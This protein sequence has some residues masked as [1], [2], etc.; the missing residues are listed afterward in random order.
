MDLIH[1][2]DDQTEPDGMTALSL[3][4]PR[5]V[6]PL[7][8]LAASVALVAAM[9]VTAQLRPTAPPA[10]PAQAPAVEGPVAPPQA[11]I[12]N[13][14]GSL[15]QIDHSIAAWTANLEANDRDF[16][17]ARNLGLLYEARARLNGDVTDYARADEAAARSLS[18]EPRQLDVQALHA[19]I[20]LATHDFSGA[21]SAASALD[22]SAP[23]QPAILAIIGDASLELGDVDAAAATYDRIDALAP[24]PAVTA[25]LARVA[26]LRG[27]A[28]GAAALAASAHAAAAADGLDGPALSWYA[29]EAGTFCL[30]GGDP[31]GAARWFDRALAAWPASYLALAG[32]ARADAALGDMDAAIAGYRAAVAIA[33]Q[34]DTLAALG[35]LLALRGEHASAEEQYATVLAIARIQGEGGLV[36]NRQLALFLVDHDRDLAEAL[37]LAEVELDERKDAYGYDAYAWALLANGRPAEASAAMAT[38]L[39]TGARDARLLFHAGEIAL[40]LGDSARARALLEESLAIRGALDPL[41]AARAAES[42]TSL[43]TRERKR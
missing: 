4:R 13:A 34:P 19:R 7:A 3:P 17:S 10:P 11:P 14:P 21:L 18:I 41:S 31:E 39:A 29:Y 27:D 42:L 1:T 35:D 33:P 36:F 23:D 37:K 9:Q 30:S 15:A 38:A 8:V 26:F 40:A 25:R 16:L 24:G 20:L 5:R 12:A 22:R 2:L 6:R 43:D 28:A 32:A